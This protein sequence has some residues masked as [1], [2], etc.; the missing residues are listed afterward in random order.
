MNVTE[1]VSVVNK[2]QPNVSLALRKLEQASL[3]SKQKKGRNCDR[4]GQRTKMVAV[5]RAPAPHSGHVKVRREPTAV[6]LNAHTIS[7]KAPVQPLDRVLDLHAG[8]N[9]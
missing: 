1:L 4:F 8:D 9:C 5:A 2:S 6:V 7:L 3:I